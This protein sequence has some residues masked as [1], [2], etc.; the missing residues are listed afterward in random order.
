MHFEIIRN[1]RLWGVCLSCWFI[2]LFHIGPLPGVNENRY[3][4]QTRS[5]VDESR[6]SINR[7]HYNTVDK[8]LVGELYYPTAAPG[9][10]LLGIPIYLFVKIGFMTIPRGMLSQ[11]DTAGYIRGFLGNQ[12]APQSFIVS[13][14]IIEFLI[15]HIVFTAL[16]CSLVSIIIMYLLYTSFA[17]F[18]PNASENYRI[19][20]IIIYAFGTLMFFYSTRLFAH[21]PSTIFLFGS[22][23]I[24]AAVRSKQAHPKWTFMAGLANG[25]ALF[26]DYLT[27]PATLVI[28]IYGLIAVPRPMIWKYILGSCL[29]VFALLAYQTICFGHPLAMPQNFMVGQNQEIFKGAMGLALP[30]L[31]ITWKLLFSAYRGFFI[32]MPIMICSV[33]VL[34]RLL[35]TFNHPNHVEWIVIAGVA[36]AQLLFNSAMPNFWNGGYIFGPRY[37]IPAIPFLIIPLGEAYRYMPGW[38]IGMAGMISILINWAGVQYIVSQTAYGAVLSFLLSGPT[39]QSYQFIETYFHTMAGW[40]VTIS[41][42]GGFMLLSLIIWGT[43]R[44]V[45]GDTPT[46]P[47]AHHQ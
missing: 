43:W 17:M 3:I 6:F 10:S 29:P 18:T 4:N 36:T 2:Y 45:G 23:L 22:F 38:L 33:Y 19:G 1:R 25:L 24:L 5:L 40:N 32:Y 46:E 39:T 37:L 20:I 16:L 8:A 35:L 31:I 30:N 11:F 44:I 42:V 15:C 27:L 47:D 41:P 9:L 7:Y 28:G 26:V 34:V 13:Y 12:D 14:P 21:I